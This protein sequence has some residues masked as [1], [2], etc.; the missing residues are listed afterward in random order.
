MDFI[1][2]QSIN[3]FPINTENLLYDETHHWGPNCFIKYNNGTQV[4]LT[5]VYGIA[6]S[7]RVKVNSNNSHDSLLNL[8]SDLKVK[9]WPLS[10]NYSGAFSGLLYDE[11][12]VTIFNDPLGI[13][14]LYYHFTEEI[15][16]ISTSL[17]EMSKIKHFDLN[18]SAWYLELTSPEYSQ[19]GTSTIFKNVSTLLPGEFILLRNNLICVSLY[20]TTIK[21]EDKSANRKELAIDLV[22]L[23]NKEFE[24]FY[25]DF[26]E[27]TIPMSGGVDSRVV[28]SPFIKLNKKIKI[29]NYGKLDVLDSYIA[30]EIANKFNFQFEIYDNAPNS[31]P[32]KDF[33]WSLIQNTDSVHVNAWF[34]HLNKIDKEN[35]NKEYFLLGDMCDILRSKGADSIKSRGFRKNYYIQNFFKRTKIKLTEITELN[36]L[37]FQQDKKKKVIAHLKNV[38]CETKF[39]PISEEEL[40]SEVEADI[41]ELFTH[42]ERYHPKF[43]ESYEELFGIFTHG[44]K[45]M[46]KQLNLLKYGYL[47]EIPLLNMRI[48]RKVLN[49][50]PSERYS[51][52]L[53]NE[54]FKVESWMPLGKFKTSQNPFVNYNSSYFVML[55]GWFIRSSVDQILTKM[56]IKGLIN[57]P[58]LFKNLNSRDDYQYPGSYER[59]VS[60]LE[61]DKMDVTK[62]KDSFLGRRNGNLWPLSSMD[63]MPTIQAI[64][65]LNRF[66]DK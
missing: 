33:I 57:R 47:P 1:F 60:C 43:I 51:D 18:Y 36:K 4:V 45:S 50:S 59:F 28:L 3:G 40:V 56:T 37:Q 53:T 13:Y 12:G 64:Y 10:E 42:M 65:Y 14:K 19:Y 7:G 22:N 23:I 55:L 30:K 25:S 11:E 35:K 48:V 17:T 15:I 26:E 52:E 49:Y 62:Q 2:V 58:R 27:L 21:Q 31:F 39:L 41:N 46:G 6:L 38:I 20:D 9:K 44:R 29:S 8:I 66:G 24:A 63:L 32:R 61:N 5:E 16:I 34:S 54:M